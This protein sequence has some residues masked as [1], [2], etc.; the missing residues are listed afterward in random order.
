MKA[1]Q[2]EV[3][4]NASGSARLP[5]VARSTCCPRARC[6]EPLA[7]RFLWRLC[8]RVGSLRCLLAARGSWLLCMYLRTGQRLPQREKVGG[9]AQGAASRHW[10]VPA[11][12]GCQVSGQ[13]SGGVA[14]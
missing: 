7:S 12:G 10:L 1:Q 3:R 5:G 14:E 4:V 13:A 6:P 8:L 11:A 2:G 9:R